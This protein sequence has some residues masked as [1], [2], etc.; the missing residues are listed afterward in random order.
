[1]K[2][3][4]ALSGKELSDMRTLIKFVFIFCRENHDGE[5]AP[6]EFKGIDSDEMDMRGILLCPDCI[7]LARYALAMRLRCPYD[8]KPMCKKCPTHCYRRNYREKIREIMKFSGL[9]L[10]KHG[11]LDMLYHYFR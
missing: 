5:K 10:V 8:P 3:K 2:R 9:Y 6:L 7:R 1:M 11:R 4:A